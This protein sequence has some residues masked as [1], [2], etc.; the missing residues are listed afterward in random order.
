MFANDS[1]LHARAKY[2]HW[3]GC[4]VIRAGT[5]ILGDPSTEFA[6]GHHQNAFVVL[7]IFHIFPERRHSLGKLFH[8]VVVARPL[9]GVGIETGQADIINPRWQ[10]PANHRRD[11]AQSLAE[12]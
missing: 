10:P 8:E 7:L 9:A 5:G 1:A 4:S 11:R 3:R 2:E 6:E 12:L